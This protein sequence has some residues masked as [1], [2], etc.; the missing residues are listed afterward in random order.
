MTFCWDCLFYHFRSQ[1]VTGTVR[2]TTC[3]K[4]QKTF[5]STQTTN[6]C[7]MQTRTNIV[8][9]SAHHSRNRQRDKGMGSKHHVG[10]HNLFLRVVLVAMAFSHML[11]RPFLAGC[12]GRHDL[13]SHVAT[14]FSCGLFWPSRPSLTC[15]HDLF[16]RVVL[17]VTT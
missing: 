2:S 9:C 16:L 6:E 1:T 10:C 7:F 3:T 13:F 14:T 11:P 4:G 8:S 17:V 5:S 12:F 15:C